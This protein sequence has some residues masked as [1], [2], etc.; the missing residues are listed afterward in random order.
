MSPVRYRR[1]GFNCEHLLIANC[2]FFL[3]SR[4]TNIIVRICY[5]MVR[6]WYSLSKKLVFVPVADATSTIHRDDLLTSGQRLKYMT[7][8]FVAIDGRWMVFNDD[9]Y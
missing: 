8:F 6:F 3:R 9:R 5:Y 7:H 1:T 2:E 4:F